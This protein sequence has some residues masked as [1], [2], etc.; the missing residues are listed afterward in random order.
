MV[1]KAIE[2]GVPVSKKALYDRHKLP[3]PENEEDSFVSDRLIKTEGE[4]SLD[5]SDKKKKKRT[6]VFLNEKKR[7]SKKRKRRT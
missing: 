6:L 4:A 5:F 1:T 3:E 7:K 2:L